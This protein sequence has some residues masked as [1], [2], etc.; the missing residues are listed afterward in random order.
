[1]A[2]CHPFLSPVAL[3]KTLSPLTVGHALAL[4]L[5]HA[6]AQVLQR[7]QA[8]A[9]EHTRVL[10]LR[11]ARALALALIGL[12][13]MAAPALAP[14]AQ[15]PAVAGAAL[16]ERGLTISGAPLQGRR[17]GGAELAGA[18]AACTGCHRRSGLG[19]FE[20]AVRVP[21]VAWRLLAHSGDEIAA[22]RTA[23][24]VLG[25]QSHR[26][27]YAPSSFAR[28]LR[29][30]IGADGRTLSWVMPRYTL[31][32]EDLA[33]LQAYLATL[34]AAPTSGSADGQLYFAMVVTP[35]AD[36]I[37]SAAAVAVI[38]R[39]FADHNSEFGGH[40]LGNGR[41][42]ANLD[43]ARL[44]RLEVW[45]LS[46]PPHDWPAQL[47]R[48]YAARPVFALVG[49]LGGDWS[50]IAD[51]CEGRHLPAILPSAAAPPARTDAFYTLYF[52]RGVRLEADLLAEALRAEPERHPVE[53]VYRPDSAGAVAAATLRAALGPDWP[54]IDRPL[55][56]SAGL[57]AAGPAPWR[58]LWLTAQDLPAWQQ[59]ASYARTYLSG[60]LLADSLISDAPALSGWSARTYLL[61]P[62]EVPERRRIPMNF[63]LGWLHSK[64]QAVVRE[65][66]QT[67]AW[68]V[69]Q[70]LSAALAD[71][72]DAYYGEYLVE[73]VESLLGHRLGNGHYP[74]LALAPGQRFASKGAYVLQ[75]TAEGNWKPDGS[76][77]IP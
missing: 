51:F 74:R 6:W 36:P 15:D 23:V 27:A 4:A 58:V 31:T 37:A 13:A 60:S 43:I 29:E 45:R 39:T 55:P 35:D 32:D 11:H 40:G 53:Q 2:A 68:L 41:D 26:P 48:A 1:M 75:W 57:H 7:V 34:A 16:Y 73:R 38:E 33:A 22:D 61:Y 54:V 72:Q 50:V 56:S 69:G 65:R 44:W 52:H 59:D 10:A 47:A 12:P 9:L 5:P 28:A 8:L 64:Q 24:H 76:W 77:K 66:V 67:D 70:I 17:E 49:G 25:A 71:L 62:W 18:E 46:G 30:G 63:P 3:S 20:G 19:T 42:T 14:A 21:P